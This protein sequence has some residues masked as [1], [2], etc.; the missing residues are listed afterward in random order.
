MGTHYRYGCVG[1]I[2]CLNKGHFIYLTFLLESINRYTYDILFISQKQ[3]TTHVRPAIKHLT[4]EDKQRLRV[5]DHEE[6]YHIFSTCKSFGS[7]CIQSK[8]TYDYYMRVRDL[9]DP[10]KGAYEKALLGLYVRNNHIEMLYGD[11]YDT[12]NRSVD[13]FEPKTYWDLRDSTRFTI[14]QKLCDDFKIDFDKEHLE[15]YDLRVYH[16]K[17]FLADKKYEHKKHVWLQSNRP[18]SEIH[19][20]HRSFVFRD[21]LYTLRKYYEIEKCIEHSLRQ[22]AS[23]KYNI[24]TLRETERKYT[25]A[26]HSLTPLQQE[27]VTNFTHFPVS[28]IYG[29][30]GTG[31]T[32]ITKE[33]AKLYKE[34][35]LIFVAPTGKAVE[36]LMKQTDLKTRCFT[37]HKLLYSNGS[38]VDEQIMIGEQIVVLD[39]Q[40][41]VDNNIIASFL[42]RFKHA[43]CRIVFMGDPYQLPPIANGQFFKDLIDRSKY[44]QVE[45]TT[46]HRSKNDNIPKFA[47]DI[48]RGIPNIPQNDNII[49]YQSSH[50]DLIVND[51]VGRCIHDIKENKDTIALCFSNKRV[52][53]LNRDIMAQ[54][55]N[56]NNRHYIPVRYFGKWRLPDNQPFKLYVGTKVMC[57]KNRYNIETK[58][59]EAANGTCGKITSLDEDLQVV[60]VEFT[61]GCIPFKGD[62]I[63]EYI[64]P[65]Y[66]ITIHKSQGS[67]YDRVIYWCNYMSYSSSNRELIYTAVTRAKS[68][69]ILYDNQTRWNNFSECIRAVRN[70]RVT[71]LFIDTKHVT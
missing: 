4:Q 49:I 19:G 53:T 11:K 42:N 27:A 51:I 10:G 7:F 41:M 36:R 3:M 25:P 34:H 26:V 60:W 9:V 71:R 21:G 39:E 40:S 59:L 68:Q 1:D 22:I 44:T 15:R 63:R 69:C 2:L 61:N 37:M 20:I 55:Q 57:V 5:S 32:Q 50:D 8:Y 62:D 38:Y 70:H 30:A 58:Q 67:E 23:N 12:F 56:T 24:N 31:K 16:I 52:A 45:L 66:A 18:I 54:L 35:S 28:I 46:I 65:A 33:I 14:V 47:Q 17:Q 48:R 64:R 6:V 13:Y 43:I 29:Q